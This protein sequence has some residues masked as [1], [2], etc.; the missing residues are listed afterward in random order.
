[1]VAFSTWK[2]TLSTEQIQD[3]YTQWTLISYLL[4]RRWT[5]IYK[6]KK[7]IINSYCI[8][9]E[10][11][12]IALSVWSLSVKCHFCQ[13]LVYSASLAVNCLPATSDRY[14]HKYA[15]KWWSGK[16]FF[17][18]SRRFCLT[19]GSAGVGLHFR[20]APGWSGRVHMYALVILFLSR[21]VSSGD[22]VAFIEPPFW[23]ELFHFGDL[24]E[25]F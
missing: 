4:F 25:N 10:K 16:K 6:N 19:P 2:R 23:Q 18:T 1:M 3:T 12:L 5:H 21:G 11:L 15:Q 14:Y 8:S 20:E 13:W 22:S 17:F 24:G 9:S 7:E